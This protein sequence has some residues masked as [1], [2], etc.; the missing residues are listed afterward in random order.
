MQSNRRAAM[1]VC[2]TPGCVLQ[3]IQSPAS[4]APPESGFCV[5]DHGVSWRDTSLYFTAFNR[6]ARTI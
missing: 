5:F 6:A 1:T 4:S 3:G 2:T